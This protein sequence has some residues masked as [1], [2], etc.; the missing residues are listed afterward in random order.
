VRIV[1][2]IA[3]V[4]ICE[5]ELR[6]NIVCYYDTKKLSTLRE[7]RTKQKY[8]DS[9][10]SSQN[11]ATFKYASIKVTNHISFIKKLKAY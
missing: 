9:Q 2:I 10:R 3:K 4:Q 7:C 1:S 5:M 8:T 11:V 6:S